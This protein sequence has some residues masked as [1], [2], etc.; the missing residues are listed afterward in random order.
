[1]FHTGLPWL[2]EE[3]RHAAGEEAHRTNHHREADGCVVRS[4]AHP[5]WVTWSGRTHFNRSVSSDRLGKPHPEPWPESQ[6]WG[7]RDN[8]H[9]SSLTMASAYLL[10][11][12]YSL[13]MEVDAEIEVYLAGHTLPS[14]HPGWSTNGIDSSRGIGR[15]LLSLSWHYL[16]TGRADLRTRISER[17]RQCIAQQWTGRNVAGPVRPITHSSPDPRIIGGYDFWRPWEDSLAILG[18]KAAYRVTGRQEAHDIAVIGAKTLF[19]FGWRAIG[20]GGEIATGLR[21]RA[22]G[23]PLTAAELSDPTQAVWSA[24]VGFEM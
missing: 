17:I 21:W 4:A 11:R 22:D 8:Q 6:G 20:N 10:T 24:G 13:E 18:L 12:S 3:A 1:M 16:L 2:V 19:T 5:N 15:T 9:W 7:G 23:T 14:T